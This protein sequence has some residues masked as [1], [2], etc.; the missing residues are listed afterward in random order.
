VSPVARC[1]RRAR[2]GRD[3]HPASHRG[4]ACVRVYIR[5]PV[6]LSWLQLRTGPW[7]RAR[8]CHARNR[9]IDHTETQVRSRSSRCRRA[10][11]AAAAAAWDS[12]QPWGRAGH[13]AAPRWGS[14]RAPG[15]RRRT[16]ASSPTFR[17]T[18]TPTGA[19]CPSKQVRT[20]ARWIPCARCMHGTRSS[21]G[22]NGCLLIRFHRFA[23]VREELPAAVDQLPPPGPQAR[24]LQRR[25]GGDRHQA[26]RLARQQ[27]RSDLEDFSSLTLL[28][29]AGHDVVEADRVPFGFCFYY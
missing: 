27:V 23:A 2:Q 12:G 10:A 22:S 1:R 6:P 14:T 20:A 26:P 9:A 25:G 17:S 29:S 5:L 21:L 19:P 18:A 7:H 13:R 3:P 4:A 8:H 16:C 15:R 24:Q 11:A 28:H